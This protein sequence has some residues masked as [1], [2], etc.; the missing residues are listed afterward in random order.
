MHRHY[1]GSLLAAGSV[2][3]LICPAPAQAQLADE[4]QL[5]LPAQD[6]SV[7]L[8]EV[9]ARTG[10]NIIAPSELV[11]GRQAPAVTGP[12]TAE[13]A[14]RILLTGSGLGVRRVG[15][16]LVVF[17]SDGPEPAAEPERA[18]AAGPGESE[19]IVVTGTNIRGA[20]PTSPLIV[21]GRQQIDESGA[22]S[23]DRL[24]ATL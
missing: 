1:I 23:V 24:L 13:G 10:R 16:S 4:V 22:S 2:A 7:S 8:R 12:F 19:P 6:L 5:A 9:S 15:D 3:A 18:A 14:V 20:Q 17:Q 11:R 21:I